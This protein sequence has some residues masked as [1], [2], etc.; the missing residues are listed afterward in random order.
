M[1]K[2]FLDDKNVFLCITSQITSWSD[3]GNSRSK[4]IE[5]NMFL[6][7]SVQIGLLLILNQ[8]GA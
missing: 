4:D 5:K 3:F 8:T 7:P 6:G 2:K 1:S